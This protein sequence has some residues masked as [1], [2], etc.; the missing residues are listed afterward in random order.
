MKKNYLDEYIF[1]ENIRN[2]RRK[3]RKLRGFGFNGV[4]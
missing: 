4:W 1:G 3:G 2:V